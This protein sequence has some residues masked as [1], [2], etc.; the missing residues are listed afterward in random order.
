MSRENAVKVGGPR[1]V[2]A[3]ACIGNREP[4]SA[5]A[6]DRVPLSV[7]IST[8]RQIRKKHCWTSQQWHPLGQRIWRATLCRGRLFPQRESKPLSRETSNPRQRTRATAFLHQFES[9]PLGRSERCT[10]GQASSGTRRP[11]KH[12]WT[13]Q[14]WRKGLTA[15]GG[16][17][18]VFCRVFPPV[19]LL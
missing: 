10:A 14:Q 5:D 16:T 1:S 18:G 2:V 13:S 6:R 11:C 8:A 12:C 4:I 7:R 17:P 15:L 9:A 19:V 3:A